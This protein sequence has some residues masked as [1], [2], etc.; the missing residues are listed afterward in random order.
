MNP[1]EALDKKYNF[2]T[3]AFQKS[4]APKQIVD[5]EGCYFTDADGN[6]FLD[7]SSQLMC[8]HLGHKNARIN[9]AMQEQA[10]KVAF[11][12]PGFATEARAKLGEK[13]AEIT[14]GNL[15]KTFYSPGGTE[16]NEAAI[17]I[18]KWF[19]GK[20]KI[21]SRYHSYHGATAASGSLTGDPRRWGMEPAMPGVIKAPSAYSYRTKFKDVMASLDYIDEMIT[22]EGDEVAAVIVEPI[23]GSNGILVPPKEY[24]PELLRICHDHGALLIADEVMSGFGRCGEWFAC[25]L[26]DVTPDIMTMAKGITAAYLPL[27]ATTVTEPIAEFFEDNFFNIG[28]T[29][30]GHAMT[31]ACAVETIQIYED[32]NLVAAAKTKGDYLMNGLCNL[33]E[34]HPCIGDVRGVG[35]FCGIELVKNRETKEPFD[36]Y[37]AKVK[38]L[39]SVVAQAAGKAMA[40]GVFVMP[41]INTLIAA[42]PLIASEEEID[43]GI[44]GLDAALSWVDTQV[45]N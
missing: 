14:P 23:V 35:L 33:K 5:A 20:H 22:L 28:H 34:K 27:A 41:M 19:T 38:G 44:K 30:T 25:D 15:C 37:N 12:A 31:V 7:F 18:A 32:E 26:W 16:A 13:L 17:M 29:Y 39:P 21:I 10:E 3:W 11:V 1:I 43:E 24:M 36:P 40:E 42:P 45:E 8:S 4:F 2:G 6:R 9:K